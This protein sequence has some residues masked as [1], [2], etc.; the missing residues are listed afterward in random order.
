MQY[1]WLLLCSKIFGG[2][3]VCLS[4]SMKSTN[5]CEQPPTQ[6]VMLLDRRRKT[7]SV[8]SQGAVCSS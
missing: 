8:C 1:A 3:T 6:I 5:V 4:E 2:A 7:Y